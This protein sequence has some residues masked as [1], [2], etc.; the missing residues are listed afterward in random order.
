MNQKEYCEA[1]HASYSTLNYW[2]RKQK[3][4][5]K[6]NDLQKINKARNPL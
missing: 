4:E 3:Q 5:I 6:S 2:N 1:F